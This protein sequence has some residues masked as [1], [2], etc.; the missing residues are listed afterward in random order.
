MIESAGK[1]IDLLSYIEQVEKL[2]RRPAFSV[3]D[4]YFVAH[5]HEL[6][7]LPELQFNLQHEGDDV[8]LKLPR[9]QEVPAPELDDLLKAWVTVSKS[10]DK[11]PEIK[12]EI[13]VDV[14]GAE[15]KRERLQDRT[16]VKAQFDWYVEYMWKPWS[17][18]ERP[19]RKAISLYNKLFALQQAIL[20]TPTEN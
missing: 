1:V 7:G 15:P 5:R 11:S 6:Q 2:K 14:S 20:L 18:T 10:P 16:A 9:L 4:E 3:P 17:Q 13:Q 19:R 8:W 12:Q